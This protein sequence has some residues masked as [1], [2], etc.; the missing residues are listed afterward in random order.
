RLR[1][2]VRGSS[3]VQV[4]TAGVLDNR[5]LK[6]VEDFGD[7]MGGTRR[8]VPPTCQG[9]ATARS[10]WNY[11]P[12]RGP[13]RHPNRIVSTPRLGLLRRQLSRCEPLLGYLAIVPRTPHRE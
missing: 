9:T 10:I 8:F 11:R 7:D 5:A 6:A 3:H 1:S 2:L 12:R 13:P 4:A